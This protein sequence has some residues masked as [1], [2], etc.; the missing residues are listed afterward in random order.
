MAGTAISPAGLFQEVRL[1]DDTDDF[2]FVVGDR[3]RLEVVAVHQSLGVAKA[4]I[5]CDAD[6]IP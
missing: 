2:C 4:V 5:G 6:D 1:G 3:Q